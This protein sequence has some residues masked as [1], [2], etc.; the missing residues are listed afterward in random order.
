MQIL[1]YKQHK[2]DIEEEFNKKE[3]LVQ[4]GSIKQISIE[5]CGFYLPE[6]AYFDKINDAPDT[7]EKATLVKKC[8]GSN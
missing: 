4:N 6:I 3:D 1:K 7:A 8:N 2:R 5:K